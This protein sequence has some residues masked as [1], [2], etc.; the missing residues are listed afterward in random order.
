MI[1]EA[2]YG[3]KAKK[4]KLPKSVDTVPS[5]TAHNRYS[6]GEITNSQAAMAQGLQALQAAQH[7]FQQAVNNAPNKKGV[8][9][10]NLIEGAYQDAQKGIN[11]HGAP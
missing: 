3:T 1:D 6:P 2:L 7:D 4:R 5:G 10:S 8:T 9:L 11:L